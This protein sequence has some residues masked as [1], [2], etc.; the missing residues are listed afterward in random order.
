MI[1]TGEFDFM[2]ANSLSADDGGKMMRFCWETVL[3]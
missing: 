3:R 1:F 2:E